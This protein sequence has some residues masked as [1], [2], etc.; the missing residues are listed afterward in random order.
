MKLGDLIDAIFIL[1]FVLAYILLFWVLP[2]TAGYTLVWFI[3]RNA[4]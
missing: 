2:F 1:G 4:T 3:L